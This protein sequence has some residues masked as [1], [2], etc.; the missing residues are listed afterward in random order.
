MLIEG[1]WGFEVPVL[2]V[3]GTVAH[4]LSQVEAWLASLV[5]NTPVTRTPMRA[6]SN[7]RCT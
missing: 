1:A 6:Q 4:R 5:D 3:N 2:E 7:E